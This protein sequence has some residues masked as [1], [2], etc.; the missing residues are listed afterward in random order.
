MTF[1]TLVVSSPSAL[2][3]KC[4]Q[5]FF[6]ARQGPF[7]LV[8]I[9]SLKFSLKVILV[10]YCALWF[11]TA[12]EARTMNE[13]IFN[14]MEF[15]AT[16]DGIT[17]DT[18]AINT[19][20]SQASQAGGG[21]VLFP[22]GV[23]LSFSIHLKS[24]VNIWLSSGA[25]LLAATPENEDEGYDSPEP[26]VWGE[27]FKYQD[28]GHSHFH[29]S[30]LWGEDLENVTIGGNGTI[31]GKGLWKGLYPPLGPAPSPR[32]GNKAIAIKRGRNITF[33]DFSI[34]RGGHFGIL[35]TG[36]NNLTIDN[37]KID[38]NRDGIDIDVC[39]NVMISNVIVNSPNDDAIVLKS[40]YV[41]G[42]AITTEN[43][44]ISNSIVSGY[45]MGTMLDG[46]YQPMTGS[47]PDGDGP[48]GRV[49]FG[50][51]SNGG[52]KRI[53]I[54]N[55]VFDHS[56]GIAIESVD[57][58][59]IEDITVSNITM[60]EVSNAP[61][62]IFLGARMRGPENTQIGSIRRVIISDITVNN[63]DGRFPI[64]LQGLPESPLTDIQ[65]RNVF[66]QFNGGISQQDVIEQ[67][68][69][70]INPFFISEHST[71]RVGYHEVPLQREAYPEPSMFGLLPAKGI[72]IRQA[73]NIVFDNITMHFNREDERPLIIMD[74]TKSI[75]LKN[76][77][78]DLE[79]ESVVLIGS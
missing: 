27:K 55:V 10:L 32:P 77:K 47:A 46:T 33:K 44:T 79:K 26:N 11:S 78:P 48:T 71:P 63:A 15:G 24:H 59:I 2:H 14:V 16:G 54:S 70:Y 25:T 74:A 42:K 31:D 13:T 37:V 62:F 6:W 36:V 19:A 1:D 50:T 65:I 69:A 58:A 5:A 57:G 4:K 38:T 20:I 53:T 61:L 3:I 60:N 17:L 43:V 52:F 39:K 21:T 22:A 68:P 45:K 12:L 51:E 76:I 18:Q 72:Y 41:F 30:L 35:A 75:E 9:M 8:V 28:F 73:E 56:R 34:F 67:N 40:S 29:N 66:V 7:L 64:I 49:K 23:Y